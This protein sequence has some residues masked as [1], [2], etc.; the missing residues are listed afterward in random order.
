MFAVGDLVCYPM[1]GV[2]R[3]ETIE[4]HTVLGV[5]G[6]YYLLRFLG[7]RMT[8]MVPVATADRVGLRELADAETCESVIRLLT[9]EACL[10]EIDNWNQR[11][12]D[13][14][15]KLR[16]GKVL[17]VANV[18]KSLLKRDRERG[19]SAGERK[20]FLTARQVLIG[21]LSASTGRPESELLWL[22]GG[23]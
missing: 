10:P 2:G 15:D 12:R 9:D 1:H 4:E 6:Q 5:T 18:V 17:D 16:A 21:E 13:N 19:L 23:E 8:A 11:Y 20:M 22:V 3:V 7:G 14:L